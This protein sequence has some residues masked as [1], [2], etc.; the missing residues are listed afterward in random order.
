MDGIKR[1]IKN[2]KKK[3]REILAEKENASFDFLDLLMQLFIVGRKNV[4]R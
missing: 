4:G 1:V 2:I 3:K